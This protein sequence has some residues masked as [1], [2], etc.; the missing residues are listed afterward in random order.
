MVKTCDNNTARR[1]TT[2]TLYL[3][4]FDIEEQVV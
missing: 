2:A 4:E 3:F 1:N